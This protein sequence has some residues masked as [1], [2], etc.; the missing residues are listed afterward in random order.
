[1]RLKD[2]IAFITGASRGLGFAAAKAFF[3]E[4]ATVICADLVFPDEK[5]VKEEFNNSDKIIF[6]KLD[7]TN[8]DQVKENAKF[9]EDKFG[10]LDILVNNAAI[11]SIGNIEESTEEDFQKTMNINVFGT[12][13][14]TKYMIPLIKKSAGGSIINI[15]SNI[16]MVGMAG[17]IAYTASKGAIVNFTRSMAL[18]YAPLNIRINAV[19][20]GAINTEMVKEYFEIN[21][22]PE[23]KKQVCAMHALNRFADPDEIAKAILFLASDESSYATG[24]VLVIDGGYTCGK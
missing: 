14:V 3:G 1:M 22:D 21:N 24:S 12:F 18:D 15:A 4:G 8:A 7:V 9:I 19:A 2:K 6:R 16:G 13:L 17:R 20:P 23:Y 11:N 5:K 10:R